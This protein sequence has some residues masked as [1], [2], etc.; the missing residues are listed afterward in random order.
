MNEADSSGYSRSWRAREWS[1]TQFSVSPARILTRP[2]DPREG[3]EWTEVATDAP[4]TYGVEVHL[5]IRDC[6][7]A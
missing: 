3:N 6:E 7:D 1:G 5:E 2:L 4:V